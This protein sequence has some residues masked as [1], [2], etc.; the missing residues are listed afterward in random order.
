M[1]TGVPPL[2]MIPVTVLHG[3]VSRAGLLGDGPRGTSSGAGIRPGRAEDYCFT[4]PPPPRK[5]FA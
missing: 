3:G 1:F 2:S 4:G 5:V